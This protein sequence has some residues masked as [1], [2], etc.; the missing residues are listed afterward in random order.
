MGLTHSQTSKTLFQVW[1]L[2]FMPHRDIEFLLYNGKRIYFE[3]RGSKGWQYSIFD[4]EIEGQY[5]L[6]IWRESE[7]YPWARSE[8]NRLSNL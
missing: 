7:P 3:I 2:I 1:N 8:T 5:T 4:D 6:K